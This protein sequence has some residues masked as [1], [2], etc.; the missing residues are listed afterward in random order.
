MSS[1]DEQK[2]AILQQKYNGFQS[3]I[4]DL[5]TQIGTITSQLEEHLIVDET[6]TKIEPEKRP[7]RKCFKMIGGVLV[8]KTIDDVIQLLNSDIKLLKEQREILAEKLEATKKSL[9]TFI[10]S[11]NIKIVRQ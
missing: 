4:T 8:E 10:E 11:N 7:G 6:L 3:D 5:Q 9:E 1:A 2:S